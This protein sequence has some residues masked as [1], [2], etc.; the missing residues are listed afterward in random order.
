MEG[1]IW[2][3]T[4]IVAGGAVDTDDHLCG[5]MA[6]YGGLFD[7][8]LCAHGCSRILRERDRVPFVFLVS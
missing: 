3:L 6:V 2:R 4:G 8:V 1:N 5:S 7:L